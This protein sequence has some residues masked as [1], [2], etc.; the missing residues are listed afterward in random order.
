MFDTHT[1]KC[2]DDAVTYRKIV[3]EK[4]IFKFILG[5][6]KELDEVRGR[7][8]RTKPLPS[9]REVFSE[10]RREESRRKV[11]MGSQDVVANT[12]LLDGSALAVQG[13]SFSS[14]DNKQRGGRPGCDHSRRP[15]HWK[16]T[17]RKIH[18]KPADWKPNESNHDKESSAN[19]A[20]SV[21]E[22]TSRG[23]FSKEQVKIQQKMVSHSL[24][25]SA[26]QPQA[27]SMMA[28][29]GGFITTFTTNRDKNG[30]WIVDSESSDHM[31]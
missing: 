28:Q 21:D 26:S 25:Q 31:T 24:L 14:Y 1:W 9:I 19:V 20:S 8:M 6:K 30:S 4:R 27:T 22:K 3:E 7:I 12:P 15:K 29:R 10:V 16:E 2:A 13:T 23:G 18:G 11:M 5:L 17:C